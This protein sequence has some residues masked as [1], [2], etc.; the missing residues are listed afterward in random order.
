[1]DTDNWLGGLANYT[2]TSY[3]WRSESLLN[4]V[5]E[6]V[7]AYID[8]CEFW[9]INSTAICWRMSHGVWSTNSQPTM[10]LSILM[11]NEV[12]KQFPYLNRINAC[13]IL[14]EEVLKPNNYTS[15][16]RQF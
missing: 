6:S 1:M 10:I 7:G 15:G 12:H 16:L 8:P 2:E 9:P 5:T 4:Y 3:A 14:I 13:I 11:T